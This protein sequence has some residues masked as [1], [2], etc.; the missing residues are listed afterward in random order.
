MTTYALIP[1]LE[2]GTRLL[3]ILN[4][5]TQHDF[6]CVVVDDGSGANYRSIFD[7]APVGTTV[8]RHERNHGKGAALKT[9]MTYIKRVCTPDDLVV[10]LDSDGQHRVED[11]L[12]CAE[13]ARHCPEALILGCR[14]FDSPQ[15]P[16]RS[17][18][19]NKVTR[20][21]LSLVAGIELNDT[22]TGLRAFSTQLIPLM[23][24]VVGERFEYETNVLLACERN[25]IAL[26]EVPIETIYLANNNGS[27]YRVLRD[28]LLISRGLLMFAGSSF[29]SFLADYLLFGLFSIAT[30][31]LGWVGVMISNVA[32]RVVSATL[33]Y[34]LN[35]TLVF[36][37]N[38]RAAQTAPQYF[39]L[40]ATVLLGNTLVLEALVALGINGMVAKL[41]VELAFFIVSWSVQNRVIFKQRAR[42]LPGAHTTINPR[43]A[44]PKRAGN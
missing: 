12:A 8:L 42:V 27:H 5:L 16:A 22:Q 40:A 35:R 44:T 10:T 3:D 25:G 29:T 23:L 18:T 30:A 24:Q 13:K 21:V 38:R 20:R 33:N 41:A 9:G 11:A 26:C 34:N 37:D 17:R 7:S 39:A 14:D 28:S 19:G 15:V 4:D 43:K 1:S 2:P 32:A 36:R 6:V 31:A